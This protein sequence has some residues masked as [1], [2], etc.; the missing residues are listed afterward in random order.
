MFCIFILNYR[1]SL[2]MCFNTVSSFL[3]L[4]LAHS[5]CL[6]HEIGIDGAALVVGRWQVR[7]CRQ[8]VKGDLQAGG[9]ILGKCLSQLWKRKNELLVWFSSFYFLLP[10]ACLTFFSLT[11][12]NLELLKDKQICYIGMY[13]FI[14]MK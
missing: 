10:H 6:L 3:W 11:F 12:K 1:T 4:F 14:W 13:H 2:P 8:V 7:M 9:R 5:H